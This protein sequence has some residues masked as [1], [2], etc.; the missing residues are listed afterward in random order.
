M[1]DP[2]VIN[3]LRTKARELEAHVTKLERALVQAK[4]DLS[5]MPP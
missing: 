2:Q 1:S 3:T 4:I 5:H